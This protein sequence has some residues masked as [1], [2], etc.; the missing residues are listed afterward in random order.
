MKQPIKYVYND[1]LQ[2]ESVFV[3][4]CDKELK[5][6]RNT[7]FLLKFVLRLFGIC[8]AEKTGKSVSHFG[9]INRKT[10]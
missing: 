2:H 10:I 4:C 1:K 5:S 9:N 7:Y 8:G 6:L 3:V